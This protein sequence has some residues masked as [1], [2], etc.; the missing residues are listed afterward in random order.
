MIAEQFREELQNSVKHFVKMQ[1]RIHLAIVL[2]VAER[3]IEELQSSQ[4]FVR[5]QGRIHLAIVLMI[6]ERF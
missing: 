1:G 5:M 6:A 4:Q 2:M 3:F